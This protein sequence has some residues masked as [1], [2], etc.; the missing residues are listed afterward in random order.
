LQAN[1]SWTFEENRVRVVFADSIGCTIETFRRLVLVADEIGFMDRPSIA[2]G[3]WG[4]VG[5]QS[6]FRQMDHSGL[7]LTI[8]VHAPPSGP[9]SAL[10]RRCISADLG[11][12]EFVRT[13]LH[14]FRRDDEFARLFLSLE[15]DYGTGTGAE[16]RAAL[17]SDPGL[18]SADLQGEVDSG[19]MYQFDTSDA[20]IN[21]L[22]KLVIE[23]STK[24]IGA[25]IVSEQTDLVPVCENPWLARLLAI[26]TAGS[27]YVGITARDAPSLGLAIARSVLPDE[28]LQKLSLEDL[29]E[30]RRKSADAYA[31]W[32]TEINKLSSRLSDL[33]P[34]RAVEEIPRI[35]STEVAPRLVEYRSE[36]KSARDHLF[37]DLVKKVATWQLPTVSIAYLADI[38]IRSALAAMAAAIVPAVPSV[39]DYF[40]KRADSKRRNAMTYLI[41][42]SPEV[43]GDR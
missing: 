22:R 8:S 4:F 25:L 18:E 36:M 23:A 5:V 11:N 21:A 14:G 17:C 3:N 34:E 2:F 9:P 16:I 37:G 35:I 27:G 28:A 15:A 32:S 30:Y 33:P 42:L 6:P 41:G 10:Y 13:F 24:V 39:V 29:F 43:K 31:A 7:P 20:R 19:S 26:R 40:V 1:R 12:A 38:S